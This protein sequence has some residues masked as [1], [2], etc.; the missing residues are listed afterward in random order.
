MIYN[1]NKIRYTISHP[2]S[3]FCDVQLSYIIERLRW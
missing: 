2:N 1:N 3:I